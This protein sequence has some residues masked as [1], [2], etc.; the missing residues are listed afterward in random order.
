[1]SRCWDLPD[2]NQRAA[3]DG[4]RLLLCRGVPNVVKLLVLGAAAAGAVVFAQ[5][6]RGKRDDVPPQPQ[7][8]RKGLLG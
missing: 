6:Q 3:H 7:H 8:K 5:Q 1:M 2:A 4:L